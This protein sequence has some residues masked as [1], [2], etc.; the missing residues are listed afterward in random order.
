[1]IDQLI[2]LAPWIVV[3][4]IY[5]GEKIQQVLQ[6]HALNAALERAQGAAHSAI[7]P[8]P[9]PVTP[10]PVPPPPVSIQ[11]AP[12]APAEPVDQ[13]FIDFVKE[14]EGF[15][16]KAKWDYKQYTNGYGTKALSADEVIDKPTAETRLRTELAASV[17]AMKKFIPNA[18]IGVQ[19][20][21]VDAIFNLGTEWEHNTLGT[22]LQQ[23]KYEEAKSH[24]MQ[25]VHAGNPPVVLDALV[26][27]RT[28]EA[29][30]FDHP[31]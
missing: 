18:P 28:A 1:M 9:V 10:R 7:I 16:P 23:G 30:M 25:Y 6:A 26:K 24:L 2:T 5:I 3:L 4:I 13:A 21:M 19:Q 12:P 29:N 15:V 27:R 14:Q 31:L 20:G 11:A 17:A 8:Q 22:L